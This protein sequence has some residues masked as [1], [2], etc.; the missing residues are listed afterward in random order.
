ME[1][2]SHAEG[3]ILKNEKL[4]ATLNQIKESSAGIEKSLN[5]SHNIRVKLLENYNEY[6]DICSQS[7]SFYVTIS[8]SYDLNPAS[9]EK[10]FLN[11]LEK[12]NEYGDFSSPF[13]EIVRKTY[14]ILNRSISRTEQPLLAL[15]VCKSAFD[16]KI[17]HLEWEM[18]I[19]N[20]ADSADASIDS[21]LPK[22]VKK[23]LISKLSNIKHQHPAFYEQL[24]IE[25]EFEW[26][27]FVDAT[28]N[29]QKYLPNIQITEFQ[30]LLV[31]QIFRP[32][33]MLSA[34]N[35]TTSNMLSL[36]QDAFM[37]SPIQQ[38][39]IENNGTI[40]II[41]SSGADPTSE[42]KDYAKLQFKEIYVGKGQ[43]IS[44]LNLVATSA[45]EGRVVCIKNIHLMPQFMQSVE[46]KLKVI[47]CNEN[48]RMIFVCET[49]KNLP[50]HLVKKYNKLF[51][52]PPVGIKHKIFNLLEQNK[53]IFKENRDYRFTKLFVA[54]F[55]LHA[56]LQ[57]RRSFIPQGWCKWYEFGEADIRAAINFLQATCKKS[58]NV[59]WII[60][61]GLLEK[62]VYGGRVDSDQDF[63]V[64]YKIY[65]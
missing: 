55:I 16:N 43:E 5:E 35:K 28:E 24:N 40:L 33:Q 17:S 53:T 49:D 21:N 23:E 31:Y 18:F 42:I 14:F 63:E 15:N 56:V 4:L 2:L 20:F 11:V 61:K 64:K 6:K 48:F 22:W 30:Q 46:N 13:A 7:A 39:L 65:P 32:D 29:V 41:A 45:E 51:M 36:K 50:K 44:N 60:L 26:R 37:Q 27:E 12:Q 9:F 58:N 34:I 54:L 8:K 47:K 57:E 52:E 59:D 10:I 62:I 19:F 38:L 3:D 25:K 1:E